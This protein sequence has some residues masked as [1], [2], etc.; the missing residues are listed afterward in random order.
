M[1]DCIAGYSGGGGYGGGGGGY[2]GG[3]GGYGQSFER[4]LCMTLTLQS[5][6]EA[7]TAVVANPAVMAA[8]VCTTN[9]TFPRQELIVLF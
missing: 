6:A 4:R 1:R 8:K 3:G 9:R 7:A 5:Q 2:G